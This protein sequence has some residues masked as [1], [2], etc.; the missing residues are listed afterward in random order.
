[1]FLQLGLPSFNT[2]MHRPNYHFSFCATYHNECQLFS[3]VSTLAA[4]DCLTDIHT[5]MLDLYQSCLVFSLSVYSV[6]CYIMDLCG[7]SQI[8]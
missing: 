6:V 3:T 5:Y 1:M 4:L 7:L 8:K 2:L